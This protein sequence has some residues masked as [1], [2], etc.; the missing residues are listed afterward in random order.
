MLGRALLDGR[1][2]G[3][4]VCRPPLAL[5]HV[6][7]V[8]L[9]VL[10]RPVEA[11]GQS[12]LLLVARD[13]Q[14]DLD[15]GGAG[16]RHGLLERVDLPVASTPGCRRHQVVDPC[17]QDVLVVRAVEDTDLARWRQDLADAPEE[18]VLQLLPGRC[19]ERGVANTLGIDRADDVA[20]DA[21]L[22]R[23]VHPLHHQKHCRCTAGSG[24][25]IQTLL[26]V[27]KLRNR[28]GHELNPGS[29]VVVVARC[30]T[31]IT[32]G[33]DKPTAR[34]QGLRE[35]PHPV[36]SPGPSLRVLRAL[37]HEHDGGISPPGTRPHPTNASPSM[38]G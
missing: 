15:D 3:L 17:D 30:R 29:L 35:R 22:A 20:H 25:G 10:L 24:V 12:R 26:Q 4:L 11:C 1:L 21:A 31:R 8:V 36:D 2:I 9:P 6:G 34:R 33:Q 19:L 7:R 5:V 38:E 23:G 28:C 13:V 27:A 37:C 14:H 32:V 18:G 16:L